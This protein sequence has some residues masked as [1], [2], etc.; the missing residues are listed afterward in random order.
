MYKKQFLQYNI[1]LKL[2]VLRG[3]EIGENIAYDKNW[4]L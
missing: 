1:Y 3:E 2:Y 4:N